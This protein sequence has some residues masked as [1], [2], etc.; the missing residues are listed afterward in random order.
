MNCTINGKKF[1]VGFKTEQGHSYG[2]DKNGDRK[3]LKNITCYITEKQDKEKIL[4][5]QGIASQYPSD[6]FN[7]IVGRKISF[8]KAIKKFNKEDRSLF[9]DAYKNTTRW[10]TKQHKK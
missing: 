5:S 1:R 4:V 8:F 6:E 10:K 2:R 7:G 3:Y 9:W